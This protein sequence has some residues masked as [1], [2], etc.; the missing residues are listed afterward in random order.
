MK[1]EGTYDVPVPRKKVWDAFLSPAQLKKAI[2]GCEKLEALGND[3]FKATMKIGVAAVKGTFE[4]RRQR[5][6]RLREG[7]HAH[8]ADG[9]R[10]R[11][12]REL[13]RGRPGGGPHRGRR[14]AD[15]G[16]RLE[17]DG[18]AV[19]R[20]DE[21]PAEGVTPRRARTPASRPP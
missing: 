4:G 17:D 8:H 10:R 7:R 15:A 20:Q 1:I 6:P 11:H 21:R 14:P 5:R 13:Q 12:A 19:L 9:D 16:R 3:E 18:R 2:P